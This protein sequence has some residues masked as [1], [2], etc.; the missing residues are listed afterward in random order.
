[1]S[2]ADDVAAAVPQDAP[3]KTWFD[4]L[5]PEAVD[6]LLELRRRYQ[7]GLYGTAKRLHIAKAAVERCQQ[8]G[9]KTCDATRMAAWLMRT[10]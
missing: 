10:D 2:L 3:R 6:E 7:A 1:M 5:P 8:R 4:M 9:W